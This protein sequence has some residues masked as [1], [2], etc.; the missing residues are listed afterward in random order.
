MTAQIKG[1]KRKI[2]LIMLTPTMISVHDLHQDIQREMMKKGIKSIS[3][4]IEGNSVS[5]SPGSYKF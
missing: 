4:G 5:G 3:C 1:N 2:R